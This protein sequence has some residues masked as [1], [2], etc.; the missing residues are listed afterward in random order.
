MD[1]D[2]Y[3]RG[4]RARSQSHLE[5]DIAAQAR[6]ET[7]RIRDDDAAARDRLADQRDDAARVRDE[8]AARLDDQT[9]RLELDPRNQNGDR[10]HGA[11]ILMRA[12]G[13]RKLAAATRARAA[14]QRDAAGSDRKLAAHDRHQAVL[15]RAEAAAELAA[16]GVDHLTKTLR[17]RVGLAAMQRELKRTDRSGE[18]LVIAFVDVVGLKHLN[19]T[20]GHIAGDDLLR[21]VAGAIRAHLRPYDLIA[22]YGGDEFV[23]SLTGIDAS[24]ARARFKQITAHLAAS[25]HEPALAVGFAERHNTESLEDLI[26]RADTA[27]ITARRATGV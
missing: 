3:V 23:C 20:D 18:R 22:R 6:S 15:D 26:H 24:G 7:A 25:P 21:A 27:M 5:R 10:L 9:E 8:L 16:E 12:A 17:R 11:E 2:E 13:L 1:M 19:D 4:G 14:Q